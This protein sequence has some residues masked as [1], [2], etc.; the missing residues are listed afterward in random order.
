MLEMKLAC[1]ICEKELQH[2][3]DALI[4]SFECTFC[5]DCGKKIHHICKNCDGELVKRPKRDAK[6]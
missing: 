2:H 6:N 1:E 5:L 3:S 4:C